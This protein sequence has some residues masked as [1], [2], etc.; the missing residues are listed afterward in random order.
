MP[1]NP[2]TTYSAAAVHTAGHVNA[3]G[4]KRE[5]TC[6]ATTAVTVAMS[7]TLHLLPM[8]TRGRRST[9]TSE[10]SI[11][12][13]PPVAAA[14]DDDDDETRIG[15]T[16]PLGRRGRLR[17]GSDGFGSAIAKDEA[18]CL[19]VVT[20]GGG[21]GNGIAMVAIGAQRLHLWSHLRFLN[22]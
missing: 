8:Y 15:K 9:A 5:R 19:W 14:D 13:R 1:N 10:N 7:T 4:A 3:K 11:L 20:A 17:A 22:L 2:V 16:R 12:P 6:V 21:A 18:F